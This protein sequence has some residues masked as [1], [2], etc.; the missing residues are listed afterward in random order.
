MT[1]FR[2]WLAVFFGFVASASFAQTDCPWANGEYHFSEQGIYGDF[3]VNSNCTEMVWKRL[4]DAEV[5]QL[6]VT[7]MGWTGSLSRVYVD[8]LEDGIHVQVTAHGGVTQRARTKR[9]N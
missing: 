1:L 7:S 6:E 9:L 2:F 3:T 5:T 8:L 4:N